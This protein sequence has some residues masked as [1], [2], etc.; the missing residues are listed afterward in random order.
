MSY[1]V[2]GNGKTGS[3][4]AHVLEQQGKDVFDYDIYD[5]PKELKGQLKIGDFFG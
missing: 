3:R 4:V 1:A 2:I 5:C